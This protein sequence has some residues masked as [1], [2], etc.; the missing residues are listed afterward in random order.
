MALFTK[1]K[2]AVG[3]LFANVSPV[4]KKGAAMAAKGKRDK[5]PVYAF[6]ERGK[7]DRKK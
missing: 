6:A 5:V 3:G 1:G 2:K 4:V 7:Q